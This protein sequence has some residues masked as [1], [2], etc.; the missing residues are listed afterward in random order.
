MLHALVA[1]IAPIGLVPL[2]RKACRP[3]RD[4][5]G[6]SSLKQ[7]KIHESEDHRKAHACH[8]GKKVIGIR[9]EPEGREKN[10][11]DAVCGMEQRSLYQACAWVYTSSRRVPRIIQVRRGGFCALEQKVSDPHSNDNHDEIMKEEVWVREHFE[12]E[13]G[14]VSSSNLHLMH[15]LRIRTSSCK[16]EPNRAM[17]MT[18][19]GCGF[20]RAVKMAKLKV[21][22]R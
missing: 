15:C 8:K 5:I 11:Y 21:M 7:R 22:S 19:G 16:N 20:Q 3:M 12:L 1:L 14:E 4:P 2:L 18:I 13:L 6:I 10:E 9:C 17:K